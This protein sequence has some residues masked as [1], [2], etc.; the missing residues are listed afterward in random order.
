MI[1]T[2]NSDNVTNCF[3]ITFNHVTTKTSFMHT[4]FDHDE[5]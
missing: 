1:E 2:K 3:N 4:F 5:F